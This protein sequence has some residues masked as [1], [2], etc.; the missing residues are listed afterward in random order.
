MPEI[1]IKRVP[2]F[3]LGGLFV[4]VFSAAF[5]LAAMD[6][7]LYLAHSWVN[8]VIAFAAFWITAGLILHGRNLATHELSARGSLHNPNPSR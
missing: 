3:S 8:G 5:A 2:T 1:S 4:F 6:R 7:S